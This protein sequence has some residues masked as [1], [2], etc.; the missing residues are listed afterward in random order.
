MVGKLPD[1][2][3]RLLAKR[4]I[5][6]EAAVDEF[7]SPSLRN[8]ACPTDLPGISAAVETI[9]AAEGK[10]VVFGDYD[11]DGICATAIVVSCLK[12][13]RPSLDV[14][15]FLPKRLEEGYGMSEASVARLLAE[16]PDVRLVVTVDNG[17]NSVE[18]VAELRARGVK[19]VVTDHH[20]PGETLPVADAVVNPKVAAPA[21]LEGLCGAGVAF[22][23]ANALV[24]TAKE[25]G[26]YEGPALGGPLLVLAGLATV[27]D[28]MPLVGQNRIIVSEALR[29]FRTWAPIGL[30]ELL[31]R[32]SRSGTVQLTT[33][34]FGF[35]IGPRINA[36]G[37]I[38]S[39]MEA[40]ELILSDDREIAR[41]LAH[42]V[43]LHN[44]ERKAKEQ[45]M[46]EAAFAKIV[47]GAAAQV[48]ELPDGHLGVVGIV[49]S[50]V[51][52]HLGDTVP[53]CVVVGG[54]GSA[55]APDG[56]N[57]RDAFEACKS[58]LT[59]YGGH[60]AAGGFSVAEGQVSR[61]REM[62]C[63]YCRRLPRPA[64]GVR[65]VDEPDF[66]VDPSAL[67]VDLAEWLTRM[68]PFGEGNPEP[69]FGIRGAVF[70]DVRPLG[71]EGKHLQVSFRDRR[72]PRAVWWNHGD[73]VDSLR[74]ASFLRRDIRFTV[75]LSTYGE[76][77]VELRLVGIVDSDDDNGID[78][79]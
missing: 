33:K 18:R 5:T 64:D 31:D 77:H 68:E 22:L 62:L 74:R 78:S 70:A 8:L 52:E 57:I 59:Q 7:F 23:L 47:P 9:L 14:A 1:I 13:L 42:I 76:R 3:A 53:V 55:R 39:G 25:R 15:P 17:I 54:H 6:G 12:A 28:I 63:D 41:E 29:R 71:A 10:V 69:V 60:A 56:I 75:E 37:R 2:I 16:H 21:A 30:R 19:V 34:D 58:V 11:C 66:W 45:V 4:G 79:F 40:L 27:T 20:L 38:A 35:T 36:A 73:L 72:I 46:T 51:M 24:S 50:R 43:D 67:T 44:T 49:A 32:A 48:I 61:F 65:K 26:L